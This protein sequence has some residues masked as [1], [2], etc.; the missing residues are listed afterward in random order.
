MTD[1]SWALV[2]DGLLNSTVTSMLVSGDNILSG[3][4]GGGVF[5]AVAR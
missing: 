1:D 3:T 2:A 5:V 4:D